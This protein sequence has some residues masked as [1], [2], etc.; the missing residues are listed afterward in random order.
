MRTVDDLIAEGDETLIVSGRA[1]FTREGSEVPSG[2]RVGSSTITIND[3]DQRGVE[4]LPD[5]PLLVYEGEEQT[6]SLRLQTEPTGPVVINLSSANSS[7]AT[8]SP[9]SLTFEVDDSNGRIWNRSQTVTVTGVD[10]SRE[11]GPDRQTRI[12]HRVSGGDYSGL[13]LS[14]VQVTVQNSG[15]TLKILRAESILESNQ[16]DYSI[17][18]SCD[19]RG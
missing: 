3:N 6:Y 9:S 14:D 17:S 13:S 1:V 18:G 19:S 2:L 4:G 10:D 8:V 11:T 5:Q 7:I 12:T 15:G 16:E